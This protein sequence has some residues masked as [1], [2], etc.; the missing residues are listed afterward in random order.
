MKNK[1]IML[2]VLGIVIVL[3]VGVLIGRASISLKSEKDNIKMDRLDA[4]QSKGLGDFCVDEANCRDFCSNNLEK[5]E[6]YCE[7]NENELCNVI[8]SSNGNTQEKTRQNGIIRDDGCEG[9]KT[10]FDFAPVNLDKTKVFL[11][12]GLMVGGHVTPIDH[13]YF[14]NFGNEEYD[15][16]IYSPGKGYITSIQHMPGAEEGKDY[17]MIIE[18]TCTISSIYIYVSNLPE[19]INRYTTEEMKNDRINIPVEEGELIGYYKNNLDYNLVDKEVILPGFIV[20]EHYRAEEWKIHVPNTY[21][22][23]NEPIRS[24][25]IELSIRIEE[26]LSGKIDYDIDG[27]LVGNWFLEG[28]DGY[29]GDSTSLERYWLGHLSF[30]YDAYDTK[31]I[32]LS[33]GNYNGEDSSQFSVKGNTPDPAGISVDDGIIKYELVRYDYVNLDGSSWDRISPVKGLKTIEIQN[34]EGIVLAQMIEGR[35]IKFEAFPKMTASQVSGFT[36]NAK[37]YER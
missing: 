16:E 3:V 36:S 11:P 34:V 29:A 25:L 23:F 2:I 5:C 26:P 19:K 17:R 33:I 22:Y 4:V 27:K 35:K 24:K 20:P 8:L 37:V 18:H 13:H 7:G 21:D 15:I 6:E 28:S 32:V 14:Q 9:T 1:K 31:R 10:K 30:V 12:L